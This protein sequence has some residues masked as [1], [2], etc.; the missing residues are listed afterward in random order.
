MEVVELRLV[1]DPD[2]NC[3]ID[4]DT[5]W[6]SPTFGCLGGIWIEVVLT[7]TT[8]SLFESHV[9]AQNE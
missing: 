4:I 9:P 1:A 6:R 8:L 7:P 3:D 2:S 5:E